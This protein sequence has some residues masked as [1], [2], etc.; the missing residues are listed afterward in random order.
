MKGSKKLNLI[1][2]NLPQMICII[3]ATIA[4]EKNSGLHTPLSAKIE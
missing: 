1:K 3:F 4:G 2:L